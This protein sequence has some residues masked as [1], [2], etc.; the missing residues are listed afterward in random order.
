MKDL[1][2]YYSLEGNTQ[3]AAEKIARKLHADVL[4]LNTVHDIPKSN[5]KYLIGG[6]QATFGLC[7]KIK[8][9][10]LNP[11][12]YDRIILGTPVW[13]N[14][15]APAV[16]SFLKKYHV[17]DKVIALFTCSGGGDNDKCVLNLR[18]KLG[19][20]KTIA[21]FA[22]EKNPIASENDR[23]LNAFMEELTRGK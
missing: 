2:V 19:N 21:A 7:V 16:K 13:A 9:L 10:D 6:M 22:D 14:K 3:Q 11:E 1:V 8:S 23:K 4:K 20:L 17:K 12:H 5:L 15:A 18:K